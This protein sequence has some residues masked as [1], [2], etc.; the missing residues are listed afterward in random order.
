MTVIKMINGRDDHRL[1]LWAI[2]MRSYKVV[3]IGILE[4]RE[5]TPGTGI[6]G[7]RTI[8]TCITEAMPLSGIRAVS[9]SIDF[10][11]EAKVD[12]AKP[13]DATA[14]LDTLS[15]ARRWRIKGEG[16]HS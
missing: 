11:R 16:F 10:I 5:T 8:V 4:R 1:A 6:I 2:A 14:Y 3:P 15:S 7:V 9:S 12:I 13:V